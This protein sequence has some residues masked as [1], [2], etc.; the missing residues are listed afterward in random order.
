MLS[1]RSH[2]RY[3]FQV[4]LFFFVT[5]GFLLVPCT[6]LCLVFTGTGELVGGDGGLPVVHRLPVS[7]RARK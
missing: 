4:F 5:L 2:L 6:P 7:L 3:F 1:Q